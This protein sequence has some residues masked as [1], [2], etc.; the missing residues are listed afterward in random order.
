M[1]CFSCYML[2]KTLYFDS[3]LIAHTYESI[4]AESTIDIPFLLSSSLDWPLCNHFSCR[5]YDL[6]SEFIK[7]HFY[8]YWENTIQRNHLSF[9]R[10][11]GHTLLW[12]MVLLNRT[13]CHMH[14]AVRVWACELIWVCFRFYCSSISLLAFY[15]IEIP[16][17]RRSILFCLYRMCVRELNAFCA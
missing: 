11:P 10:W 1:K 6:H 14:F 13:N 7:Y 8:L 4:P 2:K 12:T 17:F 16:L 3:N 9:F 5:N 15:E